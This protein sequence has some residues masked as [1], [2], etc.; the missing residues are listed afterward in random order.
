[1][2]A[3]CNKRSYNR[4]TGLPT[5][6]FR[7]KKRQSLPPHKPTPKTPNAVYGQL[8]TLSNLAAGGKPIHSPNKFGYERGSVIWRFYGHKVP[9]VFTNIKMSAAKHSFKVGKAGGGEHA[10][11]I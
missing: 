11:V 2:A 9:G 3:Y 10:V 5:L 1:M 7:S 4:A 6:A 8:A